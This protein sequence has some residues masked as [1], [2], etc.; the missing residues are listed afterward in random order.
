MVEE[1]GRRVAKRCETRVASVSRNA[2]RS[3]RID[4]RA[5]RTRQALA[6][7]LIALAPRRGFD[8]LEVR[9]LV[10][11]AG[12]GRSTFYKHYAD[13]DDFLIS[14]FAGMVAMFD[15]KAQRAGNYDAMLPAREVFAHVQSAR[16]FALSLLTSGQFA[17]T[18]AAREDRLRAIAEANLKR[19]RPGLPAARRQETAVVLAAAFVSLMR[20]WMETGMRRDASYVAGLYESVARRVSA[21]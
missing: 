17:R 16:E 6:E 15:A 21:P 14:S 7:A 10:A 9:Q 2:G 13:K 1:I 8:R 18:Q 19:L 12:I 4:R 5:E 3:G 20:W 11:K